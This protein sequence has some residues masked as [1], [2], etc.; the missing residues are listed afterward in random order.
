[1]NDNPEHPGQS[2]EDILSREVSDEALEA[3]AGTTTDAA[4]S[5][6]GAVT[7][8]VLVMC[9]GGDNTTPDEQA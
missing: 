9:C 6:P 7:I 1:M 3:A 8:N 5:L 2:D 4:M